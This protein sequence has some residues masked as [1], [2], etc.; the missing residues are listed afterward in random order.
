MHAPEL[1]VARI[2]RARI[3]VIAVDR[4]V[5]T[6]RLRIA[7]IDRAD[8]AIVAIDR[9]MHAPTHW[10]AGIDRAGVVVTTVNRLVDA[11]EIRVARIDRARIA[12]VTVD[13]RVEALSGVVIAGVGRAGIGIVTGGYTLTVDALLAGGTRMTTGA[14]VFVVVA[15]V[16]AFPATKIP[17]WIAPVIEVAE[18]PA[19]DQR[20]LVRPGRTRYRSTSKRDAT[21]GVAEQSARGA[22]DQPFQHRTTGP[23]PRQTTGK[24]IKPLLIH[25]NPLNREP[26]PKMGA[27]CHRDGEML[28]IRTATM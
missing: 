26:V 6:A 18:N 24:F 17:R 27:H 15:Q 10:V 22:C 4:R 28:R 21:G 3:T 7:R 2:N 19:H 23:A 9:L 5:H 16:D 20:P 13:R 1:R 12:V 8:I 11:A 14:A 25:V